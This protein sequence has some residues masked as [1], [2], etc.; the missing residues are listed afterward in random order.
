MI[1][2]HGETLIAASGLIPEPFLLIGVIR[3]H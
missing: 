1:G 2:I 3:K